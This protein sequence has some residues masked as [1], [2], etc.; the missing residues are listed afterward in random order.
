MN[1]SSTST[2]GFVYEVHAYLDRATQQFRETRA[3]I[4]DLQQKHR[5][6]L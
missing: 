1:S 4:S 2:D 5:S 6:E 3:L